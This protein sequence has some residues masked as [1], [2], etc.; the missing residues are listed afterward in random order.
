MSPILADSRHTRQPRSQ[1][2]ASCSRA[3]T[4]GLDKA[5][6]IGVAFGALALIGLLIAAP[7][8]PQ[9]ACAPFAELAPE[10]APLA[11]LGVAT[12]ACAL[13]QRVR[14]RLQTAVLRQL[15]GTFARAP[16]PRRPAPVSQAKQVHHA[17]A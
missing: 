9:A 17:V 4:N 3:R 5:V 6:S 14:A 8:L 16:A 15:R 11:I 10:P 2:A 1:A 7:V 13:G 12:I